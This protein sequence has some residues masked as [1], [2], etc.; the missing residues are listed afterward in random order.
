MNDGFCLLY[1]QELNLL[2][3]LNYVIFSIHIVEDEKKHLQV[4]N[5]L[6]GI[7]DQRH[8]LE[9]SMKPESTV[10]ADLK[11]MYP[12]DLEVWIFMVTV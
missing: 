7:D 2:F 10:W 6:A 1:C 5:Y 3:L 12:N 4:E 8:Q 9:E 11:K